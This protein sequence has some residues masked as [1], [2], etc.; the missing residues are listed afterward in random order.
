VRVQWLLLIRIRRRRWECV[1]CCANHRESD[2][3]RDA[4]VCP[5]VW[6]DGFEEGADLEVRRVSMA[7]WRRVWGGRSEIVIH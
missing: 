2:A 6:R 4:Q 1:P 7:V 3:E 5:R